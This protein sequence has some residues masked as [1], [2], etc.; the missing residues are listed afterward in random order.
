MVTIEAQLEG[1][2]CAGA[3]IYML[4]QR[5]HAFKVNFCKFTNET[6]LALEDA[7]AQ[8]RAALPRRAQRHVRRRRLRAGAR[9][10]RDHPGRR[11]QLG[12][13]PARD[14]RCSAC[15]RAP[16]ASRAWSTSARCAAISPTCSATLAEGMRGKRAVEWGL[17]D[18]VAPRSRFN[19]AVAERATALVD[20]KRTGRHRDRAR[21]TRA[22][23]ER[24]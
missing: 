14:R 11:R 3:N 23:R 8:Q 18:A 21:R 1:M 7:S 17:V 4:A 22:R 15:C 24:D 10:R 12:G 16:A 9:L 2:F 5:R 19:E 20:A 6:R 13:E